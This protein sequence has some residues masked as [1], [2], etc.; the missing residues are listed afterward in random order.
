MTAKVIPV[1]QPANES[2]RRAIRYLRDNLSDKYIIIHN[3]ELLRDDQVYEIDMAVI[4]PDRVY[5]V[6]VK[7]TLGRVDVHGSK[8][9]PQGRQPFHSPVAKLRD[10]AKVIAGLIRDSNPAQHELRKVWVQAVVLMTAPDS[11]VI[12][13]GRIDRN[14]VTYLKDNAKYFKERGNLPSGMLVDIRK[15]H[16]TVESVILGSVRAPSGPLKFGD[17]EVEE[18]LG[19]TDRYTEYRVHQ[20]VM[21]KTV[22]KGRLRAYEF[23]PYQPEDKRE[24]EFSIIMNAFRSISTLPPH[25]NIVAVKSFFPTEDSDKVILVTDDFKGSSLRALISNTDSTLTFDQKYRVMRDVLAGLEHAHRGKVIHRN[26]NPN[27]IV[28]GQDNRARIT[29]FDFARSENYESTIAQ[30]IIDDIDY[31]YQPLECYKDPSQ[32]TAQSDLFSAGITF[33]ELLTGELP[34]RNFNHFME[35]DGIFPN[36]PSEYQLEFPEGMDEWLQ[37]LCAVDAEVRYESAALALETFEKILSATVSAPVASSQQSQITSENVDFLDLPNGFQLNER[38]IVE[39]RLGKPGGFAVA[40]K[41]FDTFG[42][43]TRVI[44]LVIKDRYS[45][46]ERLRQ[47]YKT[48][49]QL[50]EHPNVVKVIWADQFAT[51]G[52][53]PYIVFEFLE[54]KTIDYHIQQR[55]LTFEDAISITLQATTGLQHLHD[56]EIFH[57]DIKPSNIL[58]TPNGV[59]IID[60]NLA[61]GDGDDATG[62]T[63]KYIPHGYDIEGTPSIEEKIDRDLFALAITLYQCI[64]GGEYPFQQAAF[65]ARAK[66]INPNLFPGLVNL[67]P[68]WSRFFEKALSPEIRERF[69]SAEEFRNYLRQLP[70]DALQSDGSM[71]LAE[72]FDEPSSWSLEWG[73]RDNFNP[74]VSYLLTLYSQ[75]QS[76][77]AGTRGLDN[78]SRALYVP[79]LLDT[80]LSKNILDGLFKLVII[81]GNAGDGK[82]AFIQ[83]LETIAQEQYDADYTR[84]VNGADFTISKHRFLTNYDGSQDEGDTTN[85]DV[86]L[87]FFEHF[88]G[89]E[90]GKWSKHETRIIAINEGRLVDFI[91]KYQEKFPYLFKLITKGLVGQSSNTDIEIINLNM[92]AVIA[93]IDGPNTSIFDKLIQKITKEAFWTPCKSCDL[94][95]RCYVYHNVQSL[96]DDVAGPKIHDRLKRLYIIT[97]LRNRLHITLRDLRSAL[98]YTIA[99]TRDCDDI[100]RLYNTGDSTT[101]ENILNGFYFNSWMGGAYGTDD[102]LLTLLKDVD[103]GTVPNPPLDR[104]FDFVPPRLNTNPA[105]SDFDGT[106][107]LARFTFSDRHSYDDNLLVRLFNELP[108]NYETNLGEYFVLHQSYLAMVRRRFYFERRDSNWLEMLPYQHSKHFLDIITEKTDITEEIESI[109]EAINRGEG[110]ID[111]QKIGFKLALR[112]HEITRGTIKSYRLFEGD[113]LSL[114]IP[115]FDDNGYIEYFPQGLRL[116]YTTDADATVELSINIDVYEMLQRLNDGYQPSIEDRESFYRTLAVFK[117]VLSSAPYQEVLLTEFGFE[118]HRLTRTYEGLLKYETLKKE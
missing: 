59:K 47:E 66:P 17:W 3:F 98:A 107:D 6:D 80:N 108:R 86:L 96:S 52:N 44:K 82:T 53:T 55:T 36:K 54:G 30:D 21:E 65:L 62:G 1:G 8:W 64:T 24:T 69:S 34:F 29:S 37:K 13:H 28:L 68:N 18:Q 43:V 89:E 5:I 26:L 94:R 33:F 106:T 63:K 39:E 60:F 32:A 15:Y 67:S 40:Y 117:N 79:T 71:T 38:F 16:K 97:H 46:I 116:N 103:M 11:R 81:S 51:I 50:P 74:F 12:D 75:S 19:A 76:T 31:N 72:D 110:L 41:V 73:E 90:T 78:A 101:I 20:V 61:V 14:Y 109:I 92:R 10:H 84:L 111:P 9:H 49:I 99:G 70:K 100:H 58:W 22:S 56:N 23:D 42:D 77:N 4:S 48:L 7:G 27:S 93:D 104:M 88:V 45:K 95:N 25:P 105:D 115:Q 57:Q 114:Y 102:R 83:Q 87:D 2:E 113:A 112:V 85:D 91:G 35:V 118:F